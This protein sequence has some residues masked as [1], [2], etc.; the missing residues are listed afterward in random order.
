M[1]LGVYLLASLLEI[2][3]CFAVWAWWRGSSVWWLIPGGLALA[4]FALLLALTAP[5][6]AGRSYAGYGGV[7]VTAALG[8]M[9]L[10]EDVRP[11]WADLLGGAIILVG[12]AVIL[13]SP[14]GG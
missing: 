2:S 1:G 9:W 6:T 10:V 14:R 12:A 7:Y 13:L 11:D 4:G 5:A 3:G 8:W